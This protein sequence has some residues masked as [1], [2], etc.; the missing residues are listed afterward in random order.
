MPTRST[1][2]PPHATHCP[3]RVWQPHRSAAQRGFF[4]L[5]LLLVIC[6]LLLLL[7]LVLLFLLAMLLLLVLLL[8][9][10]MHMLPRL[11]LQTTRRIVDLGCG[12]DANGGVVGA[13]GARRRTVAPTTAHAATI[14]IIRRK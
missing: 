2:A 3:K 14:N 13:I 11:E 7:L 8:V 12:A 1:T 6:M 10:C 9:L 4:D 5:R